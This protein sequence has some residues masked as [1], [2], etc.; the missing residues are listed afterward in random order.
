MHSTNNIDDGY[1]GSGQRLKRSIQKHG[2]ENHQREILFEAVDRKQLCEKEKEVITQEM[3]NDPLCMNLAHGGKG[4]WDYVNLNNLCPSSNP[5]L[6][7]LT[8]YQEAYKKSHVKI[9]R[10][11]SEYAAQHPGLDRGKWKGRKHKD[12]TRKRMSEVMK[13]RLVG[14]KNGS[15]KSRWMHKDG[16]AKRIASH[17]IISYIQENWSFGRK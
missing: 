13:G 11:N 10:K 14:E 1:L 4:S 16:V 6:R 8:K 15:Y 3:L 12:E 2:K 17:D 7:K 5:E 9:G